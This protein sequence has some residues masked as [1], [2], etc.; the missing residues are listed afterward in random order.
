[1]TEVLKCPCG[2]R[3]RR[4]GPRGATSR[5]S[6]PMVQA[7]AANRIAEAAD[8]VRLYALYA[9]QLHFTPGTPAR[10]DWRGRSW[11]MNTVMYDNHDWSWALP[12]A[13]WR[14][15]LGMARARQRG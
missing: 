11:G 6:E 14:A 2:K 12:P 4:A 9:G 15:D 8:Q 10:A 13:T 1:M 3:H 5:L 7:R